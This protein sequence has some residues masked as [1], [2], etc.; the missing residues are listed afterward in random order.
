VRDI[1]NYSL[2]KQGL[3]MLKSSKPFIF[4]LLFLF[5]LNFVCYPLL[6]FSANDKA[7]IHVAISNK[8]SE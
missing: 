6:G 4:I 8:E 2:G 3:R 1:Y 5:G 7:T